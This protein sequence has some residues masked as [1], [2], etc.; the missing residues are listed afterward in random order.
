MSI[1][2]EDLKK[3]VLDA[4]KKC[5]GHSS[6]QDRIVINAVKS[7]L[8]KETTIDH[9]LKLKILTCWH[10]LFREGTLSW[11]SD[12]DNPGEPYFHIPNRE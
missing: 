5:A 1:A 8:S 7:E 11:G 4:A 12:F 3:I 6:S 10:D 9:D 2:Y